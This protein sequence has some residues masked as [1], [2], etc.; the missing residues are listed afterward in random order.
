MKGSLK[1]KPENHELINLV[2]SKEWIIDFEFL[3]IYSFLTKALKTPR[4]YFNKLYITID[5]YDD[6]KREL[7]EI[8]EVREYL[9]F[10]DRAFPFWFYFLKVD[11][12]KQYSPFRTLIYCICEINVIESNMSFKTI[13]Y[14]KDTLREFV[15]NHLYYMRE[16]MIE[17][18]QQEK[19]DERLL[20]IL[21]L[22]E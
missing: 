15:K 12:P 17:S 14:V 16:L 20:Q 2:I 1:Q 7:Y 13:T 8:P 11:I 4:S 9:D 21:Q 22:I 19:Y 5:G 10:L 18:K 3:E 6:D